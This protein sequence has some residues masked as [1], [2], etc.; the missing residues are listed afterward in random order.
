MGIIARR[1]VAGE[2]PLPVSELANETGER[3]EAVY[4]VVDRLLA[5][6]VLVEV[7]APALG[8]LPARDLDAMSL[9]EIIETVR[10]DRAAEPDAA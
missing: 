10:S 4:S 9:S 1:F 2:T 5:A 6:S 8:L 3:P 7:E